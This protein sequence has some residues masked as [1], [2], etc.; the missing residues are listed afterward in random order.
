MLIAV[1]AASVLAIA[2]AYSASAHQRW[3]REPLAAFPARVSA[4]LAAIVAL[5]GW[6][7]VFGAVPG[8]FAWLTTV[9]IVVLL[10]CRMNTRAASAARAR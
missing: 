7:E 8:T 3:W 9:V 4:V 10:L 6:I 1:F 5:K 2:F